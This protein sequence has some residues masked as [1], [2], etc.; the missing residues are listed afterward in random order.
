MKKRQSTETGS[1]QLF[2]KAKKKRKLTKQ[3]TNQE[4][5]NFNKNKEL[6]QNFAK[7]FVEQQAQL[8]QESQQQFDIFPEDTD[9]TFK[10]LGLSEELQSLCSNLKISKPTPIQSACIPAILAGRD[11][12]GVAETGSGKTA[13]FALPVIQCIGHDP[14]G[15]FALILAPTRELAIQSEEQFKIFGAGITFRVSLIVG[16]RDQTQQSLELSKRP[17][18]VVA[19][20]GR[21]YEIMNQ[22]PDLGNTFKRLKFLVLDEA[23]RL[24]DQSFQNELKSLLTLLPQER[25][26]LLFSA[27]MSQALIKLQN[28]ALRDAFTYQAYQGLKTV[29]QLV[30]EYAFVPKFVRDATL[31]YILNNLEEEFGAR[32]AMVF[33]SAAQACF[34]LQRM[35]KNLEIE[36]VQLHASLQQRIRANSLAIFKQGQVN[37]MLATDVASR[38]LDIPTVDLVINYDVPIL[39]KDYV[40]RVGRTARAGSGGRAITFLSNPKDKIIVSKIEK[41][42]GHE[43]EECR[44]DEK[45]IESLVGLV[46][47]AKVRAGVDIMSEEVKEKSKY[48]HTGKREKQDWLSL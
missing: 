6:G 38:G 22:N 27:T 28:N 35:L 33:C 36:S 4:Q 2:S 20:P 32:S 42:I 13:A 12:I 7:L 19:T 47:K 40:H 41:L 11:V 31:Y 29:E 48:I 1:I 14:Y 16:G 3:P 10:D 45:K 34:L 25:Q 46:K 44:L 9:L 17:H 18:V 24:F 21:L 43:L 26:T 37:V 23:D 15:V 8:Q 5:D 39:A 30:E